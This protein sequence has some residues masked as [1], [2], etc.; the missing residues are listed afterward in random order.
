MSTTWLPGYGLL[1]GQ[2]ETPLACRRLILVHDRYKQ[3]V[4]WPS[5]VCMGHATCPPP[6]GPPWPWWAACGGPQGHAMPYLASYGHW[7]GQIIIGI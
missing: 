7:C 6:A 4:P 5:C 1:P 3:G 2:V